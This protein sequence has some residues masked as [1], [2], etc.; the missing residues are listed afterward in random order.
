MNTI[1]IQNARLLGEEKLTDITIEGDRIT[2]VTPA[3]SPPPSGAPVSGATVLDAAGRLV[4]PPFVDSHFHLDSV[5]TRVPN[6]T[7]TLKEGIDNWYTYKQTTLT[8][9]DV[10][11][12]AQRYCDHAF[13]MGIQAI[14]SHV[15]VCDPQLRGAEA[16]VRLRHDMQDKIDIQLVAF[17]QD[18]YLR[19]P[20]VPQLLQ[21]ALDMGVDVVGGIPHYEATME[22]GSRS[23]EQLMEIAAERKLLVDMHC[24]ESDDPLSR[25]VEVLAWHTRRLG[26]EGRVNASH[27]TSMAVMDPYYVSRKLIPLMAGAG[28]SVIA[29]PLINVHLG[30]HF[31]Y[32]RHRAM[33]PIKD[34]MA[35]GIPVG[36]AQDCNEDP[37]YPLGNADMIE[38]AKMG[39]HLGH[40]MGIDQLRKMLETVT[41]APARIMHLEGYGIAEG[42]RANLLILEATD[43][44]QAMVR[45]APPATVIRNGVVHN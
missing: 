10:Y 13:T 7:G 9:E 40:M 19:D 15:D 34:L 31:N 43:H 23:I 14:R 26:L 29:N 1:T 5:L 39:A 32:P 17:P 2:T 4:L 16:L 18:G 42:C 24:D 30:G 25:H 8:V 27:V 12:R 38:V 21:K 45:P 36:C 3:G 11:D 35:A 20:Q 37:W 44:I 28:L 6:Q 33:A 22:L 41:T